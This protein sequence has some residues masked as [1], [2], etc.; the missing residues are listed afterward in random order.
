MS[1]RLLLLAVAAFGL[2]CASFIPAEA[3][4]V[5]LGTISRVELKIACDKVQGLSFGTDDPQ[6]PFGCKAYRLGNINCSPDGVCLL[7]V[8]D[9]VP[10]LGNSLP[11]VLGLGPQQA[12]AVL[13]ANSRVAPPL[14]VSPRVHPIK[15]LSL[16]SPV[17]PIVP[18]QPAPVDSVPDALF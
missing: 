14:P 13:P 10:V 7:N 16:T 15:A 18:D 5:S 6:A 8:G 2:I 9:L 11:T 12:E 4:T 1:D 17:V 3:K